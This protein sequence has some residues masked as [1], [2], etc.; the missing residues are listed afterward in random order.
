MVL[1]K[2][3]IIKNKTYN[4]FKQKRMTT[5]SE[6]IMN[7]FPMNLESIPEDYRPEVINQTSYLMYGK[8][9]HHGNF[10]DVYSPIS[11]GEKPV[12]LGKYPLITPETALKGLEVAET[13]WE[14]GRG[15]WPMMS[16]TERIASVRE[17]AHLMKQHRKKMINMIMWEICKTLPDATIEF[18]RTIEYIMDSCVRLEQENE[19]WEQWEKHGNLYIKNTRN[20]IGI[21]LCMGPSNYPLNETFTTLIPALLMG[22]IVL[23]KPA[24]WGVLLLEPLMDCFE[25]AFPTGV[26]TTLYGNGP[27]IIPPIVRTGKIEV[28]AFIGGTGTADRIIK[29]NPVPH[30][31][32]EVLG[33]GAKNPG[34]I[35]PGAD[36]D[37]AVAACIKGTLSYNGQ[38]CTALKI[39]F[40]E[41]IKAEKFIP[42]FLEKVNK[43]KPGLPWEEGTQLTP[44]LPESIGWLTT[45]FD[46]AKLH[47]A[48]ILNEAGGTINQGYVHPAVM[49]I[50]K[51]TKIYREEQFNPL[52]PIV[53]YEDISEVLTW[54]NESKYGQQ[55]SVFGSEV[56]H[57][58]IFRI[59]DLTKNQRGRINVNTLCQRGPDEIAFTGRRDS[60]MG[61]LDIWN[62]LLAFSI[63]DVISVPHTYTNNEIFG[64]EFGFE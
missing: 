43:L 58:D 39:L 11:I 48:K 7:I 32:K 40:V 13:A 1:H 38:R 6:K 35:L 19:K 54:I 3:L 20:P 17:F 9:T 33:L 12:Y 61:T 21:V 45:L 16:K 63:E 51:K 28:F 49:E 36:T 14:N 8:I 23:F 27:E 60:A 18:D 37:E 10:Q 55:I 62:A 41:K 24:K 34:I 29:E 25:K 5:K 2:K 56:D 50:N 15:K 57:E 30:K 31:T 26:I 53:I 64:N 46:D 42:A 59:I 22:N 4:K 52:V 47:G 44:L